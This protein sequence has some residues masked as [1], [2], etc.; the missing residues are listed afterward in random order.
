[1]QKEKGIHDSIDLYY[2]DQMK[3]GGGWNDPELVRV[4]TEN[5][6]DLYKWLV[7]RGAKFDRLIIRA[8]MSALRVHHAD[9]AQVVRV[10]KEDCEK[11]GIQF[12]YETPAIELLTRPDGRVVGAITDK[13]GKK[14]YIKAKKGI[15]IATGGFCHN[16]E[17]MRNYGGVGLEKCIKYP[18]PTNTGDGL[19]MALNL[20]AKTVGMAIGTR[21]STPIHPSIQSGM[22]EAFYGAIAVNKNGERFGDESLDNHDFGSKIQIKQPDAL[23]WYIFDQ[24]IKAETKLKEPNLPKERD[25]FAIE[26]DTIEEL[27]QK[28]KVSQE[29][30]K[31]TIDKYNSDIDAPGFDTVFGRKNLQGAHG[32]LVKI[33]TSPYWAYESYPSIL[34]TSGGVKLNTRCQVIDMYN[35]VIPNLYAAGE[36]T[37]GIFG[38][39]VMGGIAVTRG[40]IQGRIAGKNAANEKS[41]K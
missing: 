18:P 32:T 17:M 26:A 31:A 24:K 12:L 33:E 20:G 36:V 5:S 30:L 37:G 3:A 2:Q 14:I 1:M 13:R 9:A 21:G 25:K 11:K 4:Y 40:W 22:R 6:P 41:W 34:G 8:G 38:L 29:K 23:G 35:R 15:V 16:V 19:Q 27:A 28:I 39:K 7:A 10:V